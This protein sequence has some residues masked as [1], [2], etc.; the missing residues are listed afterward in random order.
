MIK[1][2]IFIILLI[3]FVAIIFVNCGNDDSNSNTNSNINTTRPINTKSNNLYVNTILDGTFYDYPNTSVGKAFD[4]FFANPKWEYFKSEDGSH[5]VEFQ[6][7]AMLGDEDVLIGIQFEIDINTGRFEIVWFGVNGESQPDYERDEWLE[8]VYEDYYNSNNESS[9]SNTN[10][11]NSN[12]DSDCLLNVITTAY[13]TVYP[14]IMTF[15]CEHSKNKMKSIYSLLK[16]VFDVYDKELTCDNDSEVEKLL[17]YFV[18]NPKQAISQLDGILS[19]TQKLAFN[20]LFSDDDAI[21]EVK[22]A[23]KLVLDCYY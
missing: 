7:E 21:N 9:N 23:I 20:Q 3:L 22:E 14:N 19:G 16:S 2:N 12:I 17:N 4:N 18:K 13:G 5:I 11:S 6:G 1:K 8:V 15:G 10:I